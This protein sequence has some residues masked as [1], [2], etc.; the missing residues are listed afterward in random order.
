MDNKR[1]IYSTRENIKSTLVIFL[2]YKKSVLWVNF[3]VALLTLLTQ[4]AATYLP[5]WIVDL[6]T[7]ENA[8]TQIWTRVLPVVALIGISEL[9]IEVLNRKKALAYQAVSQKTALDINRVQV[10]ARYRLTEEKEFQDLAYES[11]RCTQTWGGKRVLTAVVDDLFYLFQAIGGFL[12]FA[13]LLS[14]VNP[15]IAVFLT[16][17]PAVPYYF[18]KKSQEFYE[19]N[20]EQWTKID[21]IQWYLLQA[22]ERLEYG[23]DVRMYSLKNW[24]LSVYSERMQERNVLDHKL[25][26]RQMTADFSDLLILLLR[27]GLCYFLL[28]NKVLTGQ[29]SAGMF[30]IMFAAVSNFS[31]CVNEIVKYYGEL[32]GDCR[33]INSLHNILNVPYQS[34]NQ[35]AENEE[36]ARELVLENVSFRY[37]E[38]KAPTIQGINLHIKAGEKVALIGVNGA[39]K[40]TLIKVL[41]GLYSS[42]TGSM[43]SGDLVYREDELEKWRG[44]FSCLFQ[45]I[46][47]L[48][49]SFAEIVSATTLEETDVNRVEHCLKMV[50]LW[51]KISGFPNG[52]YEKF[53]KL[54]ND[55]GKE[56]SGGEKQKL[57]L[58]RSLYRSAPIIILDEP[59]SALDPLAEEELYQ[60]YN[61]L[62]GGRTM[63]FV[64]HRLS[65]TRFCD[66]ILFLES[67]Q[68]AEQGTFEELMEQKGKYAE[69]FHSQAKYYAGST[70]G[71]AEEHE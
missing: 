29:I 56:L 50:G 30:V 19:K 43:R 69:M 62:F 71:E 42:D 14:T 49:Y 63:I 33:Q 10:G 12:L 55:D 16:I 15:V 57:L 8:G 38:G 47:V 1:I 2:K 64:S 6:L 58:A 27:D 48:P 32:K 23:K 31:N 24:F 59:T 37:S 54:L 36:K 11:V 65:S 53:N 17:A 26:K 3:F 40:T 18:V 22:S 4:F 51:D 67:G 13:V 45:N 44:L 20:R 41:C 39:G 5:G 28:L 46:H 35:N 52:I 68:I 9:V 66:R 25:F 21:R 70:Y 61:E 7:G 34:G 60:S